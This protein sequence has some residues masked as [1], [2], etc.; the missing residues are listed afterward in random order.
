M[1]DVACQLSEYRLRA[2]SSKPVVHV[3]H[4]RHRRIGSLNRRL[5]DAVS[6][7]PDVV[8][9]AARLAARRADANVVDRLIPTL[10]DVAEA[11]RHAR[12]QFVIETNRVFVFLGRLEVG[13]IAPI[14][15]PGSFEV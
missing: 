14:S 6:R 10:V 15:L 4:R 1:L 9:L 13:V 11:E 2:T 5:A 12:A 7:V 3:E 8:D